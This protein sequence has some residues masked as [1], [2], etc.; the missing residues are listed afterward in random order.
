MAFDNA[1]PNDMRRL[2]WFVGLLSPALIAVCVN[3]LF[4]A[5]RGIGRAGGQSRWRVLDVFFVAAVSEIL[6]VFAAFSCLALIWALVKSS[7]VERTF[8]VVGGHVWHTM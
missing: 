7:W 2:R 4:A 8:A 5:H 6:I 3:G 1:S